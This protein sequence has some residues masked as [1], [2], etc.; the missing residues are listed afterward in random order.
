MAQHPD[1]SEDFTRAVEPVREWAADASGLPV[2]HDF[3]EEHD[4]AGAVLLRPLEFAIAPATGP[5]RSHIS[6]AELTLHLLVTTVGLPALE[7]AGITSGLALAATADTGWLMDAGAPS[8]DLWRALGR[9]PAPA[10]LLHIPV[11]RLVERP[12]APLVRE[13]LQVVPAQQR[14]VVGRVVA[15]DGR[16][17]AAA[18]VALADA[19]ATPV[20]SD[21]RGRFRLPVATVA[22]APL[23]V[24]VAARGTSITLAVDPPPVD[25]D[26]DLGDLTVPVPES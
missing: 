7:A 17:L 21:H 12:P 8:H 6:S 18:R 25:A 23:T 15:S 14:V 22:G 20:I 10:F 9:P 26:G 24:S 3:D 2:V 13:P 19:G 4:G 11:R 5:V 1:L 16:P